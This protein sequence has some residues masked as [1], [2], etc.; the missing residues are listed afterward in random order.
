M[1]I[2]QYKLQGEVW[3]YPGDM[4]WH[5]VTV[6]KKESKEIKESYKGA[7]RG[8]G[9]IPVE[10]KTGSTVWQTSIFPVKDGTYILPIKAIVR[11][12]EGVFDGDMITLELRIR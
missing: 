11:K 2:K 1:K 6:G 7:R 3:I 8:F 10:V 5:F 9:A 12:K 4:A